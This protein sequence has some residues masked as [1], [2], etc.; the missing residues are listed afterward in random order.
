MCIKIELIEIMLPKLR[1]V[2]VS[3]M[4]RC[5]YPFPFPLSKPDSFAAHMSSN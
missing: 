2:N 1:K 4:M 5:L 3:A